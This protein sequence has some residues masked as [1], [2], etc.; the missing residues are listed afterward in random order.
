MRQIR[1]GQRDAQHA[2]PHA[3]A[4]AAAAAA[5]VDAGVLA[6]FRRL[7]GPVVTFNLRRPDGSWVGHREV[8]KLA[9]IHGICIRTGK[10]TL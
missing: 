10:T 8:A 9:L 6:D 7:Q 4:A 3:T 2:E 5:T 1:S